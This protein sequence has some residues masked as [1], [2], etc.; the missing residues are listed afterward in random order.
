MTT[1]FHR[2]AC[3]LL[4]TGFVLLAALYSVVNPLFEA[5]DEVWH[6]EYVRWLVEGQGLPRPEDVGA[7]PWR[8]QGSQP[9]LYYALA[10][11]L[12]APIPTDNATV[13]IRYNPHAAVGQGAAADNK[14]IMVHGAVERWPWRGVVLAAHL[15]RL[16]SVLLGGLTVVCTCQIARTLY[17][18]S[19]V[20]PS[21]AALLVAA[22]PQFLFI[23]AS[24][25]NDNLVTALCAVGLWLLVHLVRQPSHPSLAQ[26]V[27]LGLVT[28]AAALSKL[29][30]LAL[31]GLAGLTLLWLSWRERSL[32]QFLWQ[33]GLVAVVALLVAGWWYW[34]NWQLYGDPLGL[35]AMFAVLPGRG[36]PLTLA[37]V[38]SLAPGVWRSYW[39]V[40]GWFNV[41]A[42]EWLYHL[43]SAL[44]GLALAGLVLGFWRRRGRNRPDRMM[45]WV[46]LATW[47]VML[48]ALVVRWAQISYPQGRLLFPAISAAATILAVGLSNWLPARWQWIGAPVLAGLLLPAALIAPWRWIAPAYRPPQL[49]P[50]ASSLPNPIDASFAGEVALRGVQWRPDEL[51]PGALVEVEL[52]WQALRAPAANYSVFVHLVDEN[53]IVQAQRDSY[54]AGGLLPTSEWPAG[55]L[56]PDRHQLRLPAVL[57]APTRLRIEVGLYDFATGRRLPI[58]AGDGRPTDA[59]AV[60]SL[61]VLPVP[62]GGEQPIHVNFDDQIALVGYHFDRWLVTAGETLTV[63]LQWETLAAP[64]RD[65]KVFVHLLLPPDAVW[66]QRDAMPQDG[67]RPTSTWVRGERFEDRYS[68]VVPP[69]A[70]PG[71]YRVEIGLYDPETGARLMVELSDAGVPLGQVRVLS[72]AANRSHTS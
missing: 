22:N 62:P 38:W 14:N 42:D 64:R 66:A 19:R 23:S 15:V 6:Y 60:G 40:F 31:L 54:P 63:T 1:R 50:A 8:Q 65:Y 46:L 45:V 21:M 28:G 41:V 24:V 13:A 2:R 5:P 49:L 20:I 37:Q 16:F 44:A 17:P 9:P 70:P 47:T 58:D 25:S 53:G 18:E 3:I 30:G 52:Y 71:L 59:I 33:G 55:A 68:L 11:A 57:P 56:S 12:T 69:T 72:P 43:Y 10:A 61:T 35:T 27:G 39:A 4:V 34:R 51:H 48:V 36:D 29:S 67:A 7:A 32:R 26:L